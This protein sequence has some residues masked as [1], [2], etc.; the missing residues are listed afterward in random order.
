MSSES[1][2]GRQ[3][4]GLSR[5]LA[6]PLPL[7]QPGQ[8]LIKKESLSETSQQTFSRIF[9]ELG[10][11]PIAEAWAGRVNSRLIWLIKDHMRGTIARPSPS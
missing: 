7:E 11:M 8:L 4:P 6:W 5:V 1:P 3:P 9:I 10:Q 2:A